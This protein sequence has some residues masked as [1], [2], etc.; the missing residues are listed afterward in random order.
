M[1]DSDADIVPIPV[2]LNVPFS[3]SDLL[4]S[5]A[6]VSD[7][8]GAGRTLGLFYQKLGRYIDYFCNTIAKRRD[9]GSQLTTE[10]ILKSLECCYEYSRSGARLSSNFGFDYGSMQNIQQKLS[11]TGFK[12][13]IKDCRRLMKLAKYASHLHYNCA[14]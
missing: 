8:G 9:Y 7:R 5:N 1:L 11:S 13:V 6:T 2:Y 10:R 3:S 12:K 14:F 4:S